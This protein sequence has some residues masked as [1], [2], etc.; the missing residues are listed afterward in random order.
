MTGLTANGLTVRFGGRAVLD[1]VDVACSPGKVTALLGPN[2]AGK[3]TLLAC[4]AG[5]R[6]PDDGTAT[7]DGTG[8]LA[9]DRRERGRRIGLL[10]QTPDVHWDIDVATLVEL[11][12]FPHRAG[13]GRSP[14]DA[15]AVERAIAAT[16]I[17]ALRDRVVTTLSGGERSRVLLARVLAGEPA[18]LLADEPLASLDPA[19]QLDVLAVLKAA[20]S[21]G[22]GVVVVL[23][24]L[25]HALHVADD[26][27]LLRDGRVVAAGPVEAVLT[28]ARIAETYGVATEIGTAR[29]GSR[30]VVALGRIG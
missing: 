13:W 25:N 15:V 2:G 3:S 28:E 9:L 27:V 7:L 22:A 29:D 24:D 5:L 14:A 20:A 16:D 11:G 4:L 18:W 17:A 21:A 1:R 8:I 26:V 19:H 10:P 6:A 30:F 12:R 23:H